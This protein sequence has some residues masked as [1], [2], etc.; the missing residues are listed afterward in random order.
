[1]M[2]F[3]RLRDLEARA[4]DAVAPIVDRVETIR[5]DAPPVPLSRVLIAG[6]VG[7]ALALGGVGWIKRERDAWWRDKIAAS[8]SAVRAAIAKG[9]DAA[10]LTDEEIIRGIAHADDQQARAERQ[11][12]DMAEAHKE[13]ERDVCRVPAHCLSDG[14]RKQ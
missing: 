10:R 4:R 13:P 1:M 3:A 6:A 5:Y 11:L 9:G 7:V 12:R 14:V 2:Q 8:S